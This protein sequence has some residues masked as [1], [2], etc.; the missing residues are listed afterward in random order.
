MRAAAPI[1]VN[2]SRRDA[3]RDGRGARAG[4]SEPART[5]REGDERVLTVHQQQ[6]WRGK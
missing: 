2:L 3:S 5:T 1:P 4:E 6:Q